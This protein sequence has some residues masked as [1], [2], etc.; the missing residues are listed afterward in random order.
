[1]VGQELLGGSLGG[2]GRGLLVHLDGCFGGRGGRARRGGG[3]G[4]GRVGGGRLLGAA[5]HGGCADEDE[6]NEASFEHEGALPESN[7]VVYN[8]SRPIRGRV[9]AAGQV[10]GDGRA[11]VTATNAGSVE[12]A[13]N[14]RE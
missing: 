11:G 10:S 12:E 14:F 8:G 2:R 7:G 3:G 13:S 4:R 1:M 5:A 6:G 9:C